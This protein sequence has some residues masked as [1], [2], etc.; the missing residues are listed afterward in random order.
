MIRKSLGSAHRIFAPRLVAGLALCLLVGCG[1]EVPAGGVKTEND[2]A[3]PPNRSLKV[4]RRVEPEELLPR[5]LDFCVRVDLARM[6]ESLG[7]ASRDLLRDLA[8]DPLFAKAI[9]KARAVLI[10][11]RVSDLD[12]GD[13]VIAVEGD[14]GGLEPDVE[15]YQED[16]TSND[17]VHLYERKGDVKRGDTA[18]IIALDQRALVFVSAIEVDSVRRVLAKGADKDRPDPPGEGVMSLHYR[19]RRLAPSLEK[20]FPSV[21][22][23]IRELGEV[24]GTVNV[25]APSSAGS[26]DGLPDGGVVVDFSIQ[27]KS[28]DGARRASKFVDILRTNSEDSGASSLLRGIDSDLTGS[29]LHVRWVIPPEVVL[30]AIKRQSKGSE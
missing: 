3:T 8:D 1:A 17:R 27:A 10:A 28:A 18:A 30:N 16:D 25:P 20:K 4:S 26:P 22:K 19:P 24:R 9:E 2:P 13:R 14:L 11:I 21:A 29:S 23:V 15:R 12:A 5:D 6:K 7:P